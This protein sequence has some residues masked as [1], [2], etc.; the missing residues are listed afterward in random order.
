MKLYQERNTQ[1]KELP[2]GTLILTDCLCINSSRGRKQQQKLILT[3]PVRISEKSWARSPQKTLNSGH[4]HFSLEIQYFR[5]IFPSG[6]PFS[7]LPWLFSISIP[8]LN[9]KVP[10][11]FTSSFCLS[12]IHMIQWRAK[13][14]MFQLNKCQ[15]LG[16]LWNHSVSYHKYI[17]AT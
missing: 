15:S 11:S 8:E 6:F 2:A 12:E 14:I 7:T 1:P 10:S 4:G 16:K 13:I 17:Y 5:P 9:W 3:I